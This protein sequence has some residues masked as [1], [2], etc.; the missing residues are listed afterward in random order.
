MG[1]VARPVDV[2]NPKI[3]GRLTSCDDSNTQGVRGNGDARDAGNALSTQKG[4]KSQR[5][6]A[7]GAWWKSKRWKN[8]SRLEV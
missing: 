6:F 7:W 2:E 8:V 1:I 5:G 3:L 4:I